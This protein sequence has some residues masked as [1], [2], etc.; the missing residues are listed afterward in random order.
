MRR[1]FVRAGDRVRAGAPIMQIDPD[2]QQAAVSVLESQ[3]AAR[4]ADLVCE[5][6][7]RC[8]SF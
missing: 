6:A 8:I 3:R 1:I 5:A 4:E 2:R 7:A